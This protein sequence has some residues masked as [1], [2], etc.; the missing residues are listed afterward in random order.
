MI[1]QEE[2]NPETT[3]FK[4]SNRGLLSQIFFGITCILF[5]IAWDLSDAGGGPYYFQGC[6]PAI[7]SL[8]S[9]IVGFVI[10]I[11]SIVIDQ[12]SKFN[13]IALFL[14]SLTLLIVFLFFISRP[15]PQKKLPVT[16]HFVLS[17]L[18]YGGPNED[19]REILGM[20]RTYESQVSYPTFF[21]SMK[22][23]RTIAWERDANGGDRIF[24]TYDLLSGHMDRSPVTLVASMNRRN[25]TY[26]DNGWRPKMPEDLLS[27]REDA[28]GWKSGNLEVRLDGR[29][30]DYAKSFKAFAGDIVVVVS[31]QEILRQRVERATAMDLSRKCQFFLGHDLLVYLDG[32]YGQPGDAWF[33]DLTL[34]HP[35][36]IQGPNDIFPS[37]VNTLPTFKSLFDMIRVD[38]TDEYAGLKYRDDCK[39]EFGKAYRITV[40]FE[41]PDLE[42]GDAITRYDW[43]RGDGKIVSTKA[44]EFIHTFKATD[45]LDSRAHEIKVRAYDRSGQAGAWE[46]VYVPDLYFQKDIPNVIRIGS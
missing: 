21:G 9:Y 1:N 34:G 4:F 30:K 43:D 45:K 11:I 36:S 44:P 23:Y 46:S 35:R 42:Y 32:V 22:R 15:G 10:A 37:R 41:D 38:G 19:E 16:A 2:P 18:H 25:P 20:E 26:Q 24:Q 40:K 39:H 31:G 14:H 3:K 33:I 5:L 28:A 17:K 7:L 8:I 13:L 27:Y 12:K 6:L 29:W